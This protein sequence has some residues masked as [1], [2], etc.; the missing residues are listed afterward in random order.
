MSNNLP[1]GA[2]DPAATASPVA[3]G[4]LYGREP[5][6]RR[7]AALLTRDDVRLVTLTGPGGIGKTSL[8]IE[9]ARRLEDESAPS[10]IVPLAETRTNEAALAEIAVQLGIAEEGGSTVLDQIVTQTTGE[11]RL[12]VLDNL[13]Q[14]PGFGPIL[15][16]LLERVPGLSM[17]ATSRVPLHIRPEHR[18]P[19][20]P[21]ATTAGDDAASPFP[22][23]HTPAVA[24]FLDRAQRVQPGLPVTDD[25]V[26]TIA[27]I[28]Q[29]LGGMPLAIELAAARCRLLPLAVML[30]RLRTGALLLDG[31]SLDLPERQRTMARTVGWSYDLLPDSTQHAF[32][33]LA[34]F[35]GF[36][37]QQSTGVGIDET[38]L[39]RLLDTSLIVEHATE[40]AIRFRML[41]PIRQVGLRLL[42]DRH[43]LDAAKAALAQ[44]FVACGSSIDRDLQGPSPGE[45]LSEL[46]D[47]RSNLSA[48]IEWLANTRSP[49]ALELGAACWRYWYFR[50]RYREGLALVEALLDAGISGDARHLATLTNAQGAFLNE[51]GFAEQAAGVYEGAQALWVSLDDQ[52]GV[53]SAMNNRAMIELG[54]G[55]YMEAGAL[56]DSSANLFGALD[57]QMRQAQVWDNQGLVSRYLG[58]FDAAIK[59]HGKAAAQLHQL[60]N[61]RGYARALHNLATALADKGELDRARVLYEESRQIKAAEGDTGGEAVALASLAYLAA[62]SG[63]FPESNQLYLEALEINRAVGFEEGIALNLHNL[64][65]NAVQTGDL[66]G[67]L[68]YL[69]ESLAI[70]AKRGDPRDLMYSFTAWG[71]L[72]ILFGQPELGVQLTAAGFGQITR[73]G[74]TPGVSP[75]DLA[76]VRDQLGQ[77]TF[78]LLWNQGA[79]M[80]INEAVGLTFQVLPGPMQAANESRPAPP[81]PPLLPFG[82]TLTRRELDVLRLVAAGKSNAQIG[83]ALFISP[84]T[85]KTHVANLLG[86]IGVKTRAAAA[87]WAAQHQLLESSP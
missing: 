47:D 31:G 8:A 12:L 3:P 64:G 27:Q 74:V 39:G 2:I 42:A 58:A 86:K 37:L 76:A 82:Q 11:G 4:G 17:L 73:T 36:T 63:C 78:S 9:L 81:T 62:R 41:E 6:M 53:A 46:D 54:R 16:E 21:L 5:E 68:P 32:R 49:E 13:E 24:L 72:A 61:E 67:S 48:A 15:A 65:S 85:A 45:R 79:A 35:D 19:V 44:W 29:L 10:V 43:E 52:R 38:D 7:L 75:D 60:G 28:C 25:M 80:G 20:S 87:T 18:F 22:G 59:Q 57:D 40:R 77:M 83:D 69:R 66:S 33:M 51:L 30:Q 71:E 23:R 26:A 70:R 14:L 50:S 84:F 34:M 55:N 56:F 1:G